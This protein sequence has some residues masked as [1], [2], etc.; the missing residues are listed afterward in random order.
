[1]TV[2]HEEI[3]RWAEARGAHPAIVKSTRAQNGGVI[4]LDFPGYS[5][6]DSLQKISWEQ[7]FK[8]FDKNQLALVYQEKT[9]G[10]TRSNFNKLVRRESQASR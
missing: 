1:M 10:N 6:E 9:S 8:I 5:G 4:R 7:F 2:D 3:R